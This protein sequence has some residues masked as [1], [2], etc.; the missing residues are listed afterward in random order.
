MGV[1]I[2]AEIGSTH[3][4]RF[5][6]AK[7]FVDECGE[8]GVD[9]VKFQLFPKTEHYLKSGNVWLDPDLYLTIAEYAEEQGIACSASVFDEASLQM[10]IDT[11]P[12]FIKIAYSQKHQLQWIDEILEARIEPIVSSDIMH[13]HELREGVTKLYCIPEY[14]V[15]YKIDFEKIFPRF[16]GYSDHT[17]G[18][19]QTLEAV[20]HGA[21][22]IEKHVT[23]KRPEINCPDARFALPMEEFGTL[24]HHIRQFDKN[25]GLWG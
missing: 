24:I 22:I 13:D 20:S 21:K 14:P 12:Q 16:H 9:A 4:G 15:R 18:I 7:E 1:R 5:A 2:I 17:L 19:E 3:C 11:N 6:I 23:L 10:L 25:G 8:I